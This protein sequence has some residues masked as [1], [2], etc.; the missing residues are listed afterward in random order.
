MSI[1]PKAPPRIT[2]ARLACKPGTG[3]HVIDELL[4]TEPTA[5]PRPVPS[6]ESLAYHC[7][8][9]LVATVTVYEHV[10]DEIEAALA[11]LAELAPIA[12]AV[13]L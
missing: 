12:M 7:L 11:A 2:T 5:T 13:T 3:R 1:V 4:A 8:D 6:E 10:A 9:A